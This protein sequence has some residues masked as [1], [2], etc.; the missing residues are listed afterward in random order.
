MLSISV[1]PV[2]VQE[3]TL[4]SFFIF[5]DMATISVCLAVCRSGICEFCSVFSFVQTCE[6][7]GLSALTE[8]SRFNIASFYSQLLF[9]MIQ[10]NRLALS[11]IISH[12]GFASVTA[13]VLES[14]GH[15]L[16]LFSSLLAATVGYTV[17]ADSNI[18]AAL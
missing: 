15:L 6:F 8:M 1:S 5:D 2:K 18:L 9:T 17:T 3:C 14:S 16:A 10:N 11:Y 13:G 7:Q 12:S 4:I